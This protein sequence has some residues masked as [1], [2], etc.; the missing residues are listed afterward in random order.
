MAK[1]QTQSFHAQWL[2][3]ADKFFPANLES[4]MLD[5]ANKLVERTTTDPSRAWLSLFSSDETY[6]TDNLAQHYGFPPPQGGAGWV[7]YPAGFGGMV[8]QG[9]LASLGGKFGDTS[10]TLRGYELYKRLFCG[11]LGNIPPGVDIDDAPGTPGDCKT[12]RYS[13]RVQYQLCQLP[14]YYR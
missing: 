10:P 12:E 1:R 14:Q 11:E 13:M 3:Y 2:G 9:V 8:S 5:E 4:D 7:R 6:I